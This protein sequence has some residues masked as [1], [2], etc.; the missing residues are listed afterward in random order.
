[1][2]F[3]VFIDSVREAIIKSTQEFI[4]IKSIEGEP[5]LG[6]PFGKGVDKALEYVLSLSQKMGFKTKNLDGYVGYAE[7]GEGHEIVAI[8]VHVD[9]VPEGMGWTYPPYGAEIHDGKLYGRGSID[10]KGPA[11]SALYAL[12]AV[13]ESDIDLNKRVRII[14]GTNEESGWKC[15]R[16]YNEKEEMPAYCFVPDANYPIINSEK[17]IL[18]FKLKKNFAR[19]DTG[20][21]KILNIIGGERS[22]IVPDYCKT[23]LLCKMDEKVL[24]EKYKSFINKT[25]YKIELKKQ[26]DNA[27]VIKSFGTS[28]HAMTP[29]KGQNA[30]CQMI[31]FINQLNLSDSDIA[32]FLSFLAKKIGIEHYGTSIGLGFEDEISGKLTL[33]LGVISFCEDNGFVELN[34]RYPVT[35]K[36]EYIIDIIEKECLSAA[37]EITD[38]CNIDPLLVPEDSLLVKKLK[39]VYEEVT[40]QE[41]T[42]ISIGGGTYARAM[43]NAV[44]F[45]PVFPGKPELAHMKDEYI[46]IED[47]IISAKMYA[48]AICELAGN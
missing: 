27:F 29:E 19:K 11:V 10:N 43:K 25:G 45:G 15:I 4:K 31:A 38:V 36:E 32:D 13:K 12:K 40:G 7:I 20:D 6:A 24:L 28:A 35:S 8:L 33:N 42:L 44:A 48:R 34:I 1:M 14:F 30:I 9:V 16:H 41:A 5:Q 2:R 39:K 47:L 3:D 26:D 22:N 21:I 37:L 17:G 46:E 18:S 23:E